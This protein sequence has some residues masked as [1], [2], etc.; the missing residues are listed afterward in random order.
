MA[1]HQ[2]I[3]KEPARA[4]HGMANINM[5]GFCNVYIGVLGEENLEML[6]DRA[7]W[8]EEG[9]GLRLV[10]TTGTAGMC[11]DYTVCEVCISYADSR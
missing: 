5:G 2:S 6:S 10:F 7:M 11:D 9:I 8:L 1:G 4:D 3:G